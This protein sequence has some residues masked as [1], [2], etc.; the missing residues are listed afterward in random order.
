MKAI[1]LAGGRGTRMGNLTKNIPKPMVKALGKPLI[2]YTVDLL[3]KNGVDE[4]GINLFYRGEKIQKYLKD[5]KKFGVKISYAREKEL[6]GTAGAIKAVLKR[7]KF[8]APFIVVPGDSL[9]NYDIK[10]AYDSHIKTKALITV[11]CAYGPRNP[12]KDCGVMLFDKKTKK[13]LKYVQ[14]PQTKEETISRWANSGVYVLNPEITKYIPQK[15]DHSPVV[16]LPQHVIPILLKAKTRVFAFP[17][18]RN[19]YY[20]L[21][22]NNP[23]ELKQ[24]EKDIKS[25]KFEI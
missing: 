2:H 15:I 4:V 9:F 24:A 5:G 25:E 22:I 21:G 10:A 13:L 20:L 12:I 14:K 6:T 1:I 16:D 7:T 23:E 8:R 11:C 18:N 17:Y 19:K 3:I